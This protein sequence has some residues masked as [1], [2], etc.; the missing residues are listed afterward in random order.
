[1][2]DPAEQEVKDLLEAMTLDELSYTIGRY[3][4]RSNMLLSEKKFG[5]VIPKEL[6][7]KIYD[8]KVVEYYLLGKDN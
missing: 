5:F 3:T 6:A 8:T 2:K 4:G 7:E 1:M